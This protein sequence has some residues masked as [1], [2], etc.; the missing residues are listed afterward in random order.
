ML[1]LGVRARGVCLVQTVLKL[2]ERQAARFLVFAGLVGHPCALRV[3][4]EKVR[5]LSRL[6][7]IVEDPEVELGASRI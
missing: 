1:E 2:I 7:T 6:Q 5:K 4:D 3:R